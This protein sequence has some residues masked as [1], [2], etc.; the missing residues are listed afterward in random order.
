MLD[1]SPANLTLIS[2]VLDDII[3]EDQRAG[4]VIRRLRTLLKDGESNLEEVR[5]NDLVNS[6]I[7]LLRNEL[8]SRRVR[9]DKDLDPTLPAVIGDPVQLQQVL[10]NLIMNSIEA[11]HQMATAR[12]IIML[13][14]CHWIDNGLE[15]SVV[16]RGVG[17][18]GSDQMRIFEP[19]FTTKE[20]GLGLG[21][22]IC[23]TIVQRHQG[24]LTIENNPDGGATASIRL[25][26]ERK[27][28]R[29]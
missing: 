4:E 25:P 10:L 28:G 1:A 12:R 7:Q 24:T 11:V 17:I 16:D 13:K 26:L 23:S 5:L 21:L 2:E 27:R 15:I 20:R 18:S 9:I 22:S 8:I 29:R 19:F 3:H 6:T 14:T